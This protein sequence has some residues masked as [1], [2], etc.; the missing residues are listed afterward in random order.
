[1]KRIREGSP[2]AKLSR[3]QRKWAQFWSPCFFKWNVVQNSPE[4]RG[5][6]KGAA[7]AP[8][9]HSDGRVSILQHGVVR[10]LPC[11]DEPPLQ[12]PGSE[13]WDNNS[14]PDKE[15][16]AQIG[17]GR[18]RDHTT[19]TNMG[20]RLVWKA[21]SGDG[22]S[23]AVLDPTG[24][25]S[26][27]VLAAIRESIPDIEF[28]YHSGQ[29]PSETAYRSSFQTEGLRYLGNIAKCRLAMSPTLSL[30]LFLWRSAVPTVTKK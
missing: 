27:N 29:L 3:Q 9:F 12:E 26:G 24:G 20:Q 17:R 22:L 15:D 6:C 16:V 28:C 8:R 14:Q 13:Q 1:M 4:G 5:T 19:N 2:K 10:Y 7:F 25:L 30:H 23:T 11:P 18:P 21:V